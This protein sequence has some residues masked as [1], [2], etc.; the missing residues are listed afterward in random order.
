MKDIVVE[1][2]KGMVVG[3]YCDI[4]DARFV[5]VDWDLLER[6]DGEQAGIEQDHS[7]LGLLP[8]DARDEYRRA[9]SA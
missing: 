4:D 8:Q 6:P 1:V 3:L 2:R 5:V 9:I 7:N